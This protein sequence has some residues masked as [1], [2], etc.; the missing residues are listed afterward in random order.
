MRVTREHFRT[1]P[2]FGATPGF[3][4]RGGRAWFKRYGLSWA[5]FLHNGIEAD[6]LL[7]TGDGMALAI[8]EHARNVRGAERG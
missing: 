5:D 8:V 2:G 7:A 6:Q 1:C 3:C 4:A